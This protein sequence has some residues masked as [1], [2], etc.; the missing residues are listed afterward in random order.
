MTTVKNDYSNK[1]SC[2]KE[3]QPMVMNGFKRFEKELRA[4]KSQKFI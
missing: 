4:F 1:G 3:D 2:K